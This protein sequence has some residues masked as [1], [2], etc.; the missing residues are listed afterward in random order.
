MAIRKLV[1]IV[2]IAVIFL[3]SVTIAVYG[4]GRSRARWERLGAARVDGNMDHDRIPV[5][6]QD[7]RFRAIQLRVRGGAVEFMRVV[8]H[9][10]DGE[11]EEVAVKERIPNGGSTRS[12]D[13]QGNRRYIRSVELWYGR[14]GWRT[15]PEVQLYGMR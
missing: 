6:V 4:Q 11:P 3:I 8:V 15:K 1:R 5:G 10:A 14:G 13:L 12:I 2:G 9:Y 7:G